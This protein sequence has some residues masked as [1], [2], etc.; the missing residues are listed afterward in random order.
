MIN[1]FWRFNRHRNS[2]VQSQKAVTA[3]FSSE[4]FR[5]FHFSQENCT[6]LQN[7]K[8][9]HVSSY[10]LS[11]KKLPLAILYGGSVYI[12]FWGEGYHRRCRVFDKSM[13]I[14]SGPILIVRVL[15]GQQVM[16]HCRNSMK[17]RGRVVE[18]SLLY[19]DSTLRDCPQAS[20]L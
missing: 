8:E 15:P 3:Y 9:V 19:S 2:V 17:V 14:T 20:L 5:R 16:V 1:S 12:G 4:K 18:R 7:Q 13:D 11:N 6:A 10:F